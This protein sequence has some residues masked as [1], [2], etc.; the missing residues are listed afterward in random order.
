[1]SRTYKVLVG[2]DSTAMRMLIK[3]SLQD[4]EFEV[5]A[6]AKDGGEAVQSFKVSAP[7]L[8]LL[9][10]VMPVMGGV[11]ALGQIMAQDKTLW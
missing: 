10:I 6:E 8:V 11:E 1:M 2:D 4:S 7:D 9:D 3:A 5:V